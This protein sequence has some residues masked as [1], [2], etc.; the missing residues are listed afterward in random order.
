V[1]W[2]QL[3]AAK[4]KVVGAGRA[5]TARCVLSFCIIAPAFIALGANCDNLTS[6][7][8]IRFC[9]GD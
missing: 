7:E 2:Q 4:P 6:A 1:V 5:R 9:S 8:S 3:L